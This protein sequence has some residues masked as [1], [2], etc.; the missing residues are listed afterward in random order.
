MID[1][2]TTVLTGSGVG[3]VSQLFRQ[4]LLPDGD[5]DRSLLCR[6]VRRHLQP[7][8]DQPEHFLCE[9]CSSFI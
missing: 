4:H 5:V 3:Q 8:E 9:F 2:L 7:M 6:G 1:A